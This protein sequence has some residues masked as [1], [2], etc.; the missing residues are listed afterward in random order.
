M[1]NPILTGVNERPLALA[2]GRKN[3]EGLISQHRHVPRKNGRQDQLA[4]H[5]SCIARCR[6]CPWSGHRRQRRAPAYR[7][8]HK[9]E[10]TWMFGPCRVDV[11]ISRFGLRRLNK[12]LRHMNDAS[13]ATAASGAHMPWRTVP[14]P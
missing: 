6:A 9:G 4:D 7:A 11:S 2:E 12:N 10:S 13:L 5:L 3:R 1:E 8:C 14:L